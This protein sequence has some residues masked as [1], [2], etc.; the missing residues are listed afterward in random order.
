[1]NIKIRPA[2]VEDRQAIWQVHTQAIRQTA[3]SHYDAAQIEAW[4]GRLILEHYSPN[5]GFFVA[6]AENGLVV[7]FGEINLEAAEIEAV[8]VATQYARRG[9]GRRLLLFLEDLATQRG[10]TH[11]VLDAS[12][13]AVA[14]YE[15][16]GYRQENPT[17]QVYGKSAI[18]VPGMLMTKLLKG[19]CS[20]P[21]IR[22]AC[23]IALMSAKADNQ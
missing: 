13:N 18:E 3:Q 15:K 21:G 16:M 2:T 7:S 1:M 5:P 9:I 11:L 12:L 14:F 8:F 19:K 17:V 22:T 23:C 10:L 20:E 6:E 4:A